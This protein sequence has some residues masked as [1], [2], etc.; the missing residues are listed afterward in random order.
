MSTSTTRAEYIPCSKAANQFLWLKT[1]LIDLRFLEILMALFSVNHSAVD[2]ATNYR[3]SELSKYIDIHHHRIWE[4]GYN[5]TLP[6][7]YIQTMDNLADM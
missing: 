2:L 3:I 7:M 5:K 1:A 6:L 4:L